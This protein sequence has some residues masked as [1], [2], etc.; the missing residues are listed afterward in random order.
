M[1]GRSEPRRLPLDFRRVVLV[2]IVDYLADSSK[3]CGG[4]WSECSACAGGEPG[5]EADGGDIGRVG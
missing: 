4:W 2:A 1:G 5:G 3:G